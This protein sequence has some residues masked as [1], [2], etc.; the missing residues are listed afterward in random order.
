M[1]KTR[2]QWFADNILP[3]EPRV[4]AWLRKGGWSPED[5]EDLIEDL[6]QALERAK[7]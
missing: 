2:G 4:R 7:A 6:V 3:L 5:V 1:S